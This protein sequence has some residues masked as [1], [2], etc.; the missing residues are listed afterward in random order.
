MIPEDRRPY[1]EQAFGSAL[2]LSAVLGLWWGVTSLFP[3]P[4]Y[5]LPAPALVVA[6]LR[7]QWRPLLSNAVATSSVALAGL[8]VSVLVGVPAGLVIGRWRIAR[9]LLMP[10][11][12]AVQSLPKI[13][14]AP[15]FVAWLG[16]GSAP[17]L[18]VTVLV[19]FFPLTLATIV[20]VDS[21]TRLFTHLARSMGCRSARFVWHLVLPTAAPY[22]AAAFRTSATLAV[23]GTLVAEFIGSDNGLGNL[24]LI[25]TGNREIPLAFATIAVIAILGMLFY[26]GA[27]LLARAATQ[28]LRP[29]PTRNPR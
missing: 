28:H 21:L 6:A 10:P 18:I 4:R 14:L 29:P 9:R 26:A 23:M 17:K 3:I 16:F 19:T 22:I 24:L 15:L 8:L 11:L 5:V 20:G 12:I 1:G 13:V 2:V 27:A 7:E 25:T